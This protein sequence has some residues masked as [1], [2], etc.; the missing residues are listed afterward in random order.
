MRSGCLR[1]RSLGVRLSILSLLVGAAGARA[2]TITVN[3]ASDV[4]M[5]DGQ[6]TFREALTAANMNVPSGVTG[7]ECGAGSA[8]LDTIQF[9]IPGAGVHRISPGAL[10]TII[11][12]IFIDGFS[13]A[14][15]SANTNPMNAGIN[16]VILI[17]IYGASS[18][19]LHLNASNSTIRGLSIHGGGDAITINGSN[20]TITGNYI[21]TNPA[22][23]A[24]DSLPSVGVFMLSGNNNVVG[25][26]TAADRN[27][28]SGY[29]SGSVEINS[30]D[31]TLVQ[32]N[33][34]GT[35][36][37]GTLGLQDLTATPFGVQPDPL[38]TNTS[39]LGNLI[40]GN[41]TGIAGYGSSIIQGNLIGTQKD[42]VTPLPNVTY[43]IAILGNGH[44]IGGTTPAQSNTI[45]FNGFG[46]NVSSASGNR[47]QGNSIHSSTHKGIG[48]N[49]FS[50]NPLP[51]DPCD[52]DTSPGNKGQNYPVLTAASIAGGNVTISGTLNSVAGTAYRIE[53]FSSPTCNASGNGEGKTYLGFVN[54]TTNGTCDAAFGPAPFAVPGG[55]TIITATATDPAGN[56]SEF[57]AC[58]T[59]GSGGASFYGVAPC[60]VADTRNPAGPY[61]GPALAANVDRTFVIA[62]QCGVPVGAKA[63]AL[64]L[65]VTLPTAGGDLRVFP[66][67]AGLP[68]VSAINW[69]AGQTR[70]NNAVIQLGAAGDLTVHPDQPSGTV[71]LILDLN[72]YFQ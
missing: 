29:R 17:E 32:G 8:G 13:Q 37:A 38:S 33:Y 9:A 53:F 62:G 22:G 18:G 26:P 5:D 7:G 24:G 48:L 14:G 6:C 57:S 11:E 16:A 71:H 47:I 10:P 30:C 69:N 60:R 51:N 50:F 34:I 19:G 27:L 66:A 43:G 59:G 56:T 61:G 65:A 15:S 58:F 64:N 36:A 28:I 70:A 41:A 2:A 46:V 39:I 21:G 45:A 35:N 4:V 67:G 31:G 68:L 52:S 72:G 54:T 55:Q 42:G 44:L 23:T 40:A 49:G 20:V 1:R 12:P 25:G 63:V 3:T